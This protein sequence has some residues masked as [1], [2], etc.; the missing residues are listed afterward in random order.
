MA[1]VRALSLHAEY[2]CR[3]SGVCC[4]SGWRIE[5]EA[6]AEARIR[7]ALA[8]GSVRSTLRDG[9]P[10]Y[11]LPLVPEPGLAHGAG[12]RLGRHADGSCVFFDAE[13]DDL[14]AIHR[15][16]GPDSLAS[17]CR[18]FPRLA[19]LGA[20]SVSVSLS[21]HCPTAA[22]LLCRD[23][24][25][26][27]IIQDPPASLAGA[28]VEGLDARSSF[29]PLLRPGVLLGWEALELWEEHAVDLLA[30][31]ETRPEPAVAALERLAGRAASWTAA[32]GPFGPW[33][34]RLIETAGATRHVERATPGGTV[35]TECRRLW[36][37]VISATAP[38]LPRPDFPED[39]EGAWRSLVAPAWDDLSL[40]VN[41][42]LAAR[43]FASWCAL[44]GPGLRTTARAIAATLAVLKVECVRR[45]TAQ[46]CGF[47]RTD[48]REA[49]RQ[50]DLRLVHYA[51][52]Q[53]LADALARASPAPAPT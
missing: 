50:S 15:D 27:E 26:L 1:L 49:I 52:P 6:R 51:E 36:E 46:A 4:R 31:E 29:G 32:D 24:T 48:L 11:E 9:S 5:V 35:L 16:V 38:G 41:R 25:P 20:R 21:H 22:D 14:C 34:R 40:V 13:R 17:S 19:L 12:C 18:Q 33:F 43:A 47:D 44:Q 37:T 8:A 2:R 39:F 42:Y 53:A 7:D 28:D 3:H 45:A 10:P 30:R 23:D